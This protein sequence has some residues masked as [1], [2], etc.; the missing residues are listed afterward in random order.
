LRVGGGAVTP[1]DT[2]AD[3]ATQSFMVDGAYRLTIAGGPV[4][5]VRWGD[6][7]ELRV[8]V[9]LGDTESSAIITQQI[10]W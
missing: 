8:T 4:A 5:T 6:R 9:D 7:D 10:T 1:V 3:D 2:A